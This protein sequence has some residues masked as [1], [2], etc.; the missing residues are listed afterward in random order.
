MPALVAGSESACTTAQRTAARH[1]EFT[2][3]SLDHA[4]RSPPSAAS[5]ARAIRC[6]I[7][8]GRCGSRGGLGPSAAP[9]AGAQATGPGWEAGILLRHVIARNALTE[10]R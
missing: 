1:R 8:S 4:H 5:A 2:A 9:S 6:H 3:L 7:S 10:V